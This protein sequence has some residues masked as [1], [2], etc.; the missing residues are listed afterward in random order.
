M[1]A[2]L[3]LRLVTIVL[4]L[5]MSL[6]GVA[7]A[8]AQRMPT[9]DDLV[10]VEAMDAG[11]TA[12]DFCGKDGKSLLAGATAQICHANVGTILPDFRPTPVK[13]ALRVV[14]AVLMTSPLPAH[15]P[16]D[17]GHSSRAPPFLLN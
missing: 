11:A 12:S 13:I 2:S 9:V 1:T 17:P 14:A 6:G 7:G 16:L 5:V 4:A 10:I 15:R 8:F 3:R